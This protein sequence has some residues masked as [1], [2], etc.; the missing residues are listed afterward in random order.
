MN[1][2]V[3]YLKE[4]TGREVDRDKLFEFLYAR[5]LQAGLLY[6]R[7]ITGSRLQRQD[8]LE[9]MDNENIWSDDNV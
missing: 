9:A 7:L 3:E 1:D 8:Y 4:I 6:F 5:K 2:L